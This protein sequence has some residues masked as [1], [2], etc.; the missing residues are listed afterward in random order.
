MGVK[1][2]DGVVICFKE[3]EVALSKEV[4]A[5]PISYL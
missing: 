1:K 3:K 4:T 5:I 2:G